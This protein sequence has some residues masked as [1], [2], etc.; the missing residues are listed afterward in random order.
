VDGFRNV[1]DEYIHV[2]HIKLG[3]QLVR[4][5]RGSAAVS[6]KEFHCSFVFIS[7]LVTPGKQWL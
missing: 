6:V 7:V 1:V 3:L 4:A 2:Q 5:R